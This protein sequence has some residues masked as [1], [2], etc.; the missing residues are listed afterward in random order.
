MISR[1]LGLLT[2]GTSTWIILG[3][4]FALGMAAG[5][6]PVWIWLGH[7][8]DAL[9]V[10]VDSYVDQ[11]KQLN[12]TLSTITSDRDAQKAGLEQAKAIIKADQD[13][14]MKLDALAKQL[15]VQYNAAKVSIQLQRR[16]DQNRSSDMLGQLEEKANVSPI[17]KGQPIVDGW[18]PL[19]LT[20]IKWV[21]CLQRADASGRQP[22][23]CADGSTPVSTGSS[24]L[25]GS[26]GARDYRPTRTQQLWLLGVVYRERDWG[27]SLARQL[28]S[29][30]DAQTAIG[31]SNAD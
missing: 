10:K 26:T 21:Q 25:G 3:I 16:A 30:Q 29:I 18:D 19:V 31:A 13:Q 17:T 8:I 2:G 15:Q 23:S 24:T 27:V 28:K 1:F 9:E 6:T 7:D 12:S 5:G 20:G 4:I 14:M 22:T 11:I